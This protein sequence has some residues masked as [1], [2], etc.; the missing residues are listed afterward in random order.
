MGTQTASKTITFHEL[1][2]SFTDAQVAAWDDQSCD[3]CSEDSDRFYQLRHDQ[4]AAIVCSTCANDWVGSAE[5][6]EYCEDMGWGPAPQQVTDTYISHYLVVGGEG[7]VLEETASVERAMEYA[8]THGGD[9]IG[10]TNGGLNI[11]IPF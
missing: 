10:V 3:C 2:R 6:H 8:A 4:N 9:I 11:R 1:Y 5:Y 7:I